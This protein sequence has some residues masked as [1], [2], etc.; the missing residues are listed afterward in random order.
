M[1]AAGNTAPAKP[2][3]RG[4]ND[5][6]AGFALRRF[7]EEKD[8]AS[9]YASSMAPPSPPLEASMTG[10]SLDPGA[11]LQGTESRSVRTNPVDFYM[12]LNLLPQAIR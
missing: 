2:I 9:Q 4:S 3:R 5:T 7:V 6:D 11:T 10:M 12:V 8:R 1:I